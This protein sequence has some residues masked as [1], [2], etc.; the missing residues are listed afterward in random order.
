MNGSTRADYSNFKMHEQ[1]K[2]K[3]KIE[4]RLE[5]NHRDPPKNDC[6]VPET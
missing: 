4:M 5:I 3:S 2:L 6:E 1:L